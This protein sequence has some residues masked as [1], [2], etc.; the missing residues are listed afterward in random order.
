MGVEI[1]KEKI[2]LETNQSKNKKPYYNHV[3]FKQSY[4]QSASPYKFHWKLHSLVKLHS[5]CCKN[6]ILGG[7]WNVGSPKQYH[8]P[9]G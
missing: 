3:F 1:T 4:R 6:A 2:W 9:F 5:S 7:M 8:V